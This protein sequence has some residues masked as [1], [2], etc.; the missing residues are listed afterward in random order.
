MAQEYIIVTHEQITAMLPE[1]VDVAAMVLKV[2]AL[3]ED[4]WT[5]QGGMSVSTI[6]GT[7]AIIF[8]QAMVRYSQVPP[9]PP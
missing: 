1:T 6:W 7:R 4:G 9:P 2:Q 8:A 5:C 3:M